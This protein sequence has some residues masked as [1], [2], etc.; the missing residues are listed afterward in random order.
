MSHHGHNHKKT[1][2]KFVIGAIFG[3]IAGAITALLTAPKSGKETREDLKDKANEYKDDAVR[4]LRKLEGE[5]NKKTSDVRRAAHKIEG[6]YKDQADALVAKAETIKDRTLA[7]IEKLKKDADSKLDDKLMS[8]V[9]DVIAK[10]DD[11]R[12]EINEAARKK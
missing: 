6:K 1:G 5:L 11:L 8:D 10:L 12:D 7:G 9:K 3:A 4:Q 2:G